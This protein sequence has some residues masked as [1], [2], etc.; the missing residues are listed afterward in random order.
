MDKGPAVSYTA[1]LHGV[2][3]IALAALGYAI[4]TTLAKMKLQGLDPIGLATTQLSLASLML[5]PVAF[6]GPHPATLRS[7]SVGA[8]MLLGFAGSG[9]AFLLYY[10]LLAHISATRVV[11]VTYLL[12]LWGLFWGH[13]A[14]EAI[15]WTAYAGVAIVILGL[16]LLNL[17]A[18]QTAHPP[19]PP[20]L[21]PEPQS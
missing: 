11:A 6:A 10:N 21:K 14:H 17:R 18:F 16:V 8:V 15:G 20:Q 5:L 1:Y 3:Y 2:V 7:A 4:A 13:L 19:A 12:P 9:L